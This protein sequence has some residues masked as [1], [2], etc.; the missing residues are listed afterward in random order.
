MLQALPRVLEF[1][2]WSLNDLYADG[3]ERNDYTGDI[4][5]VNNLNYDDEQSSV[6]KNAVSIS[7]FFHQ[8]LCGAVLTSLLL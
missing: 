3:F 2:I 1:I 7:M 6:N 8:C 4:F 5:G